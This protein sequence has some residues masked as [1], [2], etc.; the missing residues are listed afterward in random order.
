MDYS[1]ARLSPCCPIVGPRPVAAHSFMVCVLVLSGSHGK[2]DYYKDQIVSFLLCGLRNYKLACWPQSLGSQSEDDGDVS[3][4][5]RV[6]RS[7]AR[8]MCA[9]LPC[10]EG[11]CEELFLVLTAVYIG[12]SF[13]SEMSL[14]SVIGTMRE[15]SQFPDPS[16]F[17]PQCLHEGWGQ[18]WS[19]RREEGKYGVREK[20]SRLT[21]GVKVSGPTLAVCFES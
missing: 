12:P 13:I 16:L 4:G 20:Q 5:P 17:L 9:L 1:A 10:R 8:V 18:W 21:D 6:Q 14:H 19:G 3:K 11:L 7:S 2:H 15:A